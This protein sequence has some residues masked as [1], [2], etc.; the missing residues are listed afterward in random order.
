MGKYEYHCGVGCDRRGWRYGG[1]SREV[2]NNKDEEGGGEICPWFGGENYLQIK[3]EDWNIKYMSTC[4][5]ECIL[6]K[7]E[8]GQG[9]EN[10]IFYPHPKV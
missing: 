5:L 4:F 10:S 7:Y 9:G 8:V 1:Q 2:K 6:G 3:F